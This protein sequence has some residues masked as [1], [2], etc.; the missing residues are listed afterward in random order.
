MEEQQFRYRVIAEWSEEDQC[1][2]ARAPAFPGLA[3]HGDTVEDATREARVA[4]EAMLETLEEQ[5]TAAPAEDSAADYS[6][7]FR[8]RI[9]SS[10][11]RRIAAIAKA[12]GVS[13]NALVGTMLAEQLGGRDVAAAKEFV[14]S[15]QAAI[16]AAGT[17]AKPFDLGPLVVPWKQPL[18]AGEQAK[19][20]RTYQARADRIKELLS[21]AALEVDRMAVAP[22]GE[23]GALISAT[24]DD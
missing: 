10:M 6:G 2:V 8:L 5:G 11:H 14:G 23:L 12:E 9:P 18:T 22:A 21:G 15:M 13:L 19:V 4:G 20:E 3:A 1:F 7:Q 24:D 17:L 16:T